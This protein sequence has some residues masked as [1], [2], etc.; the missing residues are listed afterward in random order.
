VEIEKGQAM[1]GTLTPGTTAKGQSRH[2]R[3]M[4]LLQKAD[5]CPLAAPVQPELAS[6][7]KAIVVQMRNTGKKLR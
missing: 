6:Y 7:E 4:K 3:R 2:Q 5:G 1:K